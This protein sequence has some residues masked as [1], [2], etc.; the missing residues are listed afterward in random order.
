MFVSVNVCDFVCPSV[1]L[2]KAKVAGVTLNPACAPVPVSAI[3]SDGLFALLVTVTLPVAF[4]PVAGANTTFKVAVAA[5]FNVRGA[6]I[7]LTL[8]PAPLAAML[9]IWTGAVPV[10]VNVT[11]FVALPPVPTLPKLSEAGFACNCPNVALDPVPARETVSVGLTGSLLVMDKVPVAAPAVVGWKE[12]PAVADWPAGI[13]FG[14][15]IPLTPNWAPASETAEIV[16]S[17]LP[18]F[19]IVKLKLLVEPTPTVPN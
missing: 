19:E 8:K 9:E 18:E 5:A 1:T 13:V 14:V 6:V 10:L 15:A 3:V 12:R 17:A 2:P 11:C 4:P 7:P 16:R